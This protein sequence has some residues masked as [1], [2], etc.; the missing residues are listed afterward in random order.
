MGSSLGNQNE[1]VL[2]ISAL[3]YRYPGADRDVL[4]SIDFSVGRGEVFGFLGPNGS[5]K[6]T[7]QKLLTRVLSGYR[8]EV[9]VFGQAL[10]PADAAYAEQ[11]GVCFE[12]PNLYEK[13]TAEEN[14][15]FHAGFFGSRTELPERLLERFDL[16]VGDKRQVGQY[17]KGMKMRLVLARSLLNAPKLWFLDE[18][19]TGQDPEHAHLIRELIAQ[20][21]AGGT[22]VFLTTHNMTVAEELCDRVAFL[23]DG[24]IVA[25]ESPK[26][27]RL[28][29]QSR[30]ARVEVYVDGELRGQDFSLRDRVSKQAFATFV[31]ENEVATIHTLEPSLEDIFLELAG[32]GLAA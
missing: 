26:V 27:L 21:A 13:L 29:R 24:E 30:M 11:I 10:S 14:L 22:T 15:R 3:S 2:D 18:P 20:Q 12:F 7:T 23:V 4:R 17:S 32:K 1:T 8:G 9:Q 19:T 31:S 16:P 5:G 28:R 25:I 6:T